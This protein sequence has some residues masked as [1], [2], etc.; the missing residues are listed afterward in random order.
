MSWLLVGTIH[1]AAVD[2]NQNRKV[3]LVRHVRHVRRHW[4]RRNEAVGIDW[5]IAVQ[6]HILEQSLDRDHDFGR[7]DVA[8]VGEIEP[9]ADDIRDL[10][11][12]HSHGREELVVAV[13][14][15]G[16][17]L[18]AERSVARK[19]RSEANAQSEQADAEVDGRLV[20]AAEKR[21]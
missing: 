7:A 17:S 2:V 15:D 3:H 10:M 6:V 21:M 8:Q 5:N 20:R 14:G 4:D 12:R 11:D 19:D 9:A 18:V 13:L 1:V 16:G